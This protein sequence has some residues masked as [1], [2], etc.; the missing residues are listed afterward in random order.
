MVGSV[1]LRTCGGLS[2]TTVVSLAPSLGAAQRTRDHYHVQAQSVIECSTYYL[3]LRLRHF[4]IFRRKL[5]KRVYFK[6]AKTSGLS[7]ADLHA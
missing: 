2:D 7:R 1:T 3:I 6:K 5:I 4:Y